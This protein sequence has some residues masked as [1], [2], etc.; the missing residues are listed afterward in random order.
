MN[1]QRDL[2]LIIRSRFPIVLIETHE[3]ARM[4]A[5]LEQVARLEGQGLFMWSA[6]DGLQRRDN[7]LAAAPGSYSVSSVQRGPYGKGPIA[8]TMNI[9]SAL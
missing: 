8:D 6:A 1:D 2:S 7:P 5:L 3:E 4:M 9:A